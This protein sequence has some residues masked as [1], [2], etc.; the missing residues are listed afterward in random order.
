MAQIRH[1]YRHPRNYAIAVEILSKLHQYRN[2]SCIADVFLDRY[3]SILKF[4][5]ATVDRKLLSFTSGRFQFNLYRYSKLESYAIDPYV[6]CTIV[7]NLHSAKGVRNYRFVKKKID[8]KARSALENRLRAG[9][10]KRVNNRGSAKRKN[11]DEDRAGQLSER[12][13]DLRIHQRNGNQEKPTRTT[14]RDSISLG[15]LP[16]L[17]SLSL[18]FSSHPI[19]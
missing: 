11:D 4:T 1:V 12:S 8:H 7:C 18:H 3:F 13:K 5:C 17:P 14:F 16:P 2:I 19:S 9:F 10:S 15:V 6:L